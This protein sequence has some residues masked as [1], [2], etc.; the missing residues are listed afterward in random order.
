MSTV[1]FQSHAD[2]RQTLEQVGSDL[3]MALLLQQLTEQW[4]AGLLDW[5]LIGSFEP[6]FLD[7]EKLIPLIYVEAQLWLGTPT[8]SHPDALT[9]RMGC[10][11]ALVPVETALWDRFQACL[12]ESVQS[13]A[14]P[15]VSESEPSVSD[16]FQRL[17]IQARRLR[18][19]DIHL[20]P[21]AD[22]SV[23]ARFRVDG[24]LHD[25]ETLSSADFGYS[26]R[27]VSKIKVAADLD[28]A[29][30]R[31]PQD[32]RITELIAGEPVDLR[33]STL[34]SMHGEKVVIRLL[35]HKN[36][37]QE[38]RDLGLEGEGLLTYY[39][40]IK[41]PQGMI[42]I[43]GQTGSGKTSTLYT[44]LSQ[45]MQAEK[46]IVTIEDPIEYQLKGVT[47][48]QVHPKV[49]LTFANGLRAIL[50]QDPDT[51]LLGEIRDFETAEI[52]YQAALTGHM[53]LSTLHTNDAP[54]AIIR[55]M[56]I[57]VEPYLI[58]S[59]TLGV[60][61][62]RLLRKVCPECAQPYTPGQTLI[63]ELGLDPRQ[64]YTFYKAVGCAQCFQTGYYGREGIFEVMPVDEE[65]AELITQKESLNFIRQH[66]QAQKIQSLF[67]SAVAK[68][69]QGTTTVEEIHRVVPPS[70]HGLR[71]AASGSVFVFMLFLIA[72]LSVLIL[73]GATLF[74]GSAALFKLQRE[75]LQGTY[76]AQ[77]ALTVGEQTLEDKLGPHRLYWIPQ[78][79]RGEKRLPDPLAQIESLK[80]AFTHPPQIV[81]EAG[82][83]EASYQIR[84]R[85]TASPAPGVVDYAYEIQGQAILK[86]NAQHTGSPP[87]RLSG[88]LQV[89][90]GPLPL[91][92]F[93]RFAAIGPIHDETAS[94]HAGPWYTPQTP[95]R[96]QPLPVQGYYSQSDVTATAP[97]WP[98]I[99]DAD[100]GLNPPR[101][102]V[103]LTPLKAGVGRSLKIG[104]RSRDWQAFDPN[105]QPWAVTVYGNLELL[106]VQASTKDRQV[107]E[108]DQTLGPPGTPDRQGYQVVNLLK[109]W[110]TTDQ[111]L[112]RVDL[113]TQQ[114]QLTLTP[115]K[116]ISRQRLMAQTSQSVADRFSGLIL[117]N[118]SIQQVAGERYSRSLTV[119]A[120]ND[121]G[122]SGPMLRHPQAPRAALGLVSLEG[123][124]AFRPLQPPILAAWKAPESPVTVQGALAAA[125][126]E[127]LPVQTIRIQGSVSVLQGPFPTGLQTEAD[128]RLQG[129]RN[130]PPFYPVLNPD[131]MGV[132]VT[133]PPH[134]R[135]WAEVRN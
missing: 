5:G 80:Q 81:L 8:P 69:T 88:K 103:Y 22:Q 55:L 76:A 41:K 120:A 45:M 64:E 115:Q 29:E 89:E 79:Q 102:S 18:A 52:A 93:E 91:S 15:R 26:T 33:V 125:R 100:R 82:T 50:R 56:D 14:E 4:D 57:H 12:S 113:E 63:R 70:Q 54:S 39:N 114:W 131:V 38:L 62:Q 30:T 92:F 123:M 40:W 20:E 32:G 132:L 134:D 116:T 106:Q 129:F 37:F 127:D 28:I 16:I 72:I 27:L 104:E 44:T 108:L 25:M 21:Q 43:T 51:I 118:G 53:V 130:A 9:E 107:L 49:G 86:N 46:N 7:Q 13:P 42:L 10:P 98:V 68:L 109:T 59:A 112:H 67:E 23:L 77:A 96:D 87:Q 35:P 1:R 47:Q 75:A 3:A 66:L 121:I 19:S 71:K 48:V 97:V 74:E 73:N 105:E 11:I 6:A 65:L 58:A 95:S 122:V 126:Y 24:L 17:L 34:P 133:N 31:V 2:F 111:A 60:V 78:D 94:K 83:L 135:Q 110:I 124:M 99:G 101:P 117:V 84:T 85:P 128:P 61:A 90:T 36:P 119:Y